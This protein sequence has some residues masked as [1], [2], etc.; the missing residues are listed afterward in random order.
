MYDF[1]METCLTPYI[2]RLHTNTDHLRTFIHAKSTLVAVE[3]VIFLTLT[4]VSLIFLE[5]NF[6]IQIFH[7]MVDR[8]SVCLFVAGSWQ[9][10]SKS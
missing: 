7:L 2:D 8:F 9:R 3:F 1:L 4:N 6:K 10:R 5:G